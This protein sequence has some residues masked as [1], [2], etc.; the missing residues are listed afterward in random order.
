[1]SEVKDGAGRTINVENVN[2]AT[3]KAQLLQSLA[4][5]TDTTNASNQEPVDKLIKQI[6]TIAG[7]DLDG[8]LLKF[9]NS[10]A[11]IT[12]IYEETARNK[13]EKK[14]AKASEAASA[15][16]SLQKSLK[17]ILGKTENDLNN[18]AVNLN[19]SL[20]KVANEIQTKMASFRAMPGAPDA[21]TKTAP[22]TAKRD[23]CKCICECIERMSGKMSTGVNKTNKAIAEGNKESK[24][25]NKKLKKPPS[26]SNAF[27][28]ML[29]AFNRKKPEEIYKEKY[30]KG[31]SISGK[32]Q[33]YTGED[34]KKQVIGDIING[35]SQKTGQ[36]TGGIT[37]LLGAA[38]G[39]LAGGLIEGL[40]KFLFSPLIKA[41]ED[42]SN[43]A[44]LIYSTIGG[45][46]A[47]A[48]KRQKDLVL[49]ANEVLETGVSYN[50]IEKA[51]LANAKKGITDWNTTNKV[52][53][54]GLNLASQIG[55]K[56]E[57]AA[58]MFGNWNLHLDLS[59]SKLNVIARN[60][61]AI[62]RQTGLTG[63]NLL[64]VAQN[65]KTFMDNMRNAGTFTASA[66]N[67]IIGFLARAEKT[68]NNKAAQSV[69]GVL[70]G[71][72]T[73]ATDQPTANLL[74]AASGGNPKILDQ[75]VTGTAL[76][77]KT[78]TKAL[79]EGILDQLS[80]IIMAQTGGRKSK[81]SQLTPQ[82]AGR[83]SM[84]TQSAFKQGAKEMELL[85]KNFIDMS[86]SVEQQIV[87]INKNAGLTPTEKAAQIGQINYNELAAKVSG[88]Q[89]GDTA[90][91]SKNLEAQ[92]K[93]LQADTEKKDDKGN[94]VNAGAK[95]I[96]T[97][98]GV[99]KAYKEAQDAALK[100]GGD[101]AEVQTKLQAV[102]D[103]MDAVKRRMSEDQRVN[104][105]PMGA[106][107]REINLTLGKIQE[108]WGKLLVDWLP[109]ITKW[110]EINQPKI[111]K[112][113]DNTIPLM[114]G[115]LGTMVGH[116]AS[117]VAWSFD[118]IKVLAAIALALGV[119]KA[120]SVVGPAVGG[121]IGRFLPA[122]AGGVAAGGAA[123]GGAAAGGAA[124]G[125]TAAAGGLGVGG[126]SL[127]GAGAIIGAILIGKEIK[128]QR[129][130]VDKN[131]DIMLD[132]SRRRL[133]G[134][135]AILKEDRTITRQTAEQLKETIRQSE[136]K[137]MQA[138]EGSQTLNNYTSSNSGGAARMLGIVSDELI[139]NTER[140]IVDTIHGEAAVRLQ[141][142]SRL[143]AYTNPLGTQT[144]VEKY[145]NEVRRAGAAAPQYAHQAY[146]IRQ[147]ALKESK[148]LT[149]GE[150]MPTLPKEYQAFKEDLLAQ[151][152]ELQSNWEM[153]V[154]YTN[155]EKQKEWHDK[156][157]ALQDKLNTYLRD[158]GQQEVNIWELN[159]AALKRAK[160][161][162]LA[163]SLKDKLQSVNKNMGMSVA[164]IA[165]G[166]L[167]GK[168]GESNFGTRQAI[169]DNSLKFIYA[170]M[171][172]ADTDVNNILKP[173][174][175]DRKEYMET[176]T[177]ISKTFEENP[178]KL[179]QV[180]KE[181]LS[182]SKLFPE[183]KK[184][185]KIL[186]DIL[187]IQETESEKAKEYYKRATTGHSIFTHDY[188]VVE[189]LDWVWGTL[190]DISTQLGEITAIQDAAV[191]TMSPMLPGVDVEEEIKKRQMDK[192]DGTS[193]IVANTGDTAENTRR[194]AILLS[195]LLNGM[196][197]SKGRS[198]AVDGENVDE[199]VFWDQFIDSDWVDTTARSPGYMWTQGNI[200]KRN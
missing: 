74:L 52:T 136:L 53:K 2:V 112:F 119:A 171:G 17:E 155:P 104:L 69:L 172:I 103:A 61:L 179:K 160:D 10:L 7:Y 88:F 184:Y 63:D 9:K 191:A 198:T 188:N 185:I 91:L 19:K 12:Q 54:T 123:A 89:G 22:V 193:E 70:Q 140:A 153:E 152:T 120:A 186:E 65:S 125:G 150:A 50:A 162:D 4:P 1:M 194:T 161:L 90:E 98:L 58:E 166:P 30:A 21:A 138:K 190:N 183:D 67:N 189:S 84:V 182:Q 85:G 110:L 77:D 14:A 129:E 132:I 15:S 114:V 157:K 92:F 25:S 146:T 62:G 133:A 102:V 181:Y 170:K 108:S 73:T 40:L 35:V 135:N 28:D 164:E 39:G 64:K 68:G 192:D 97:E 32:L 59:S 169:G 167:P 83:V 8:E 81:L 106:T 130:I 86:K 141:A 71:S 87:D 127:L 34:G 107:Q 33:T 122:A 13:T 178:D 49:N 100:V 143:E 149:L 131:N 139:R 173:E 126:A 27:S 200:G 156:T 99:Q 41:F 45:N 60:M 196:R 151:F 187:K 42:L 5:K 93:M 134:I 26:A 72:I 117:L 163:E 165:S 101:P 82:E 142:K 37:A 175:V 145:G 76:G 199:S 36:I 197:R 174:G 115:H 79:G 43:R 56:A 47:D 105:D 18:F 75:L 195:A 48:A 180:L 159:K 6:G 20:E 168:P 109:K 80:Q 55:A 3:L 96:F 147:N 24:E 95:S 137:T 78:T 154:R 31:Q 177:R 111:E 94:L 46:A 144:R 158:Q 118:N 176:V 11:K 16:A 44:S 148:I 116:L 66:A 23:L 38:T 124:A 128:D 121:L 29:D 51:R 57:D 113:M